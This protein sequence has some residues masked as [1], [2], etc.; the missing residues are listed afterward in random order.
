MVLKRLSD[1][2]RDGDKIYAVIKGIGSSSDGKG[3]A[4]YAPSSSGQ[5]K[6]LRNAYKEAGVDPKSIELVECHGTGTKVGD[7]IELEALSSVYREAS[8]EGEWCTLGSVK[9]QIDIRIG[10]GCRRSD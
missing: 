6:A 2:E 10:G 7:G 8:A 1:A 4:I 9:S 3:K 5:M